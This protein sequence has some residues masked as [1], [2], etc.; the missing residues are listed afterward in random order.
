MAIHF[1]HSTSGLRILNMSSQT[2]KMI[3]LRN[4]ESAENPYRPDLLT[5]LYELK[6]NTQDIFYIIIST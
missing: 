3:Q 4:I 1:Y 6:E 2:L 5:I